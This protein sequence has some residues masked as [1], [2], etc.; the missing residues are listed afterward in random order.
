MP[1]LIELPTKCQ[2][3]AKLRTPSSHRKC[4]FCKN[5]GIKEEVLCHLN[6]CIQNHSDFKCHA[7]QPMLK[8]VNLPRNEM[9][10]YHKVLEER[11]DLKSSL[12]VLQSDKIK[13][14]RALALQKLAR[15]P[16][17]VFV[18]LK[19]HFAWNVIHRRSVFQQPHS[20][21]NF[22]Y[23]SVSKCSELVRGFV[24]LLWIAPDHLHLYVESDGELSVETMVQGIKESIQNTIFSGL[25]DIGD[26]LESD[27]SFWDGAYFS[28]TI[29]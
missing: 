25:T 20:I 22:I 8:I 1:N 2:Q 15:D 29:G 24:N 16:D 21:F 18:E 17:G 5:I 7:F 4:N 13:Y 6:R 14:E 26:N 9:K 23:D 10:E 19:Y 12:R 27:T 28:E 3:C 11:H